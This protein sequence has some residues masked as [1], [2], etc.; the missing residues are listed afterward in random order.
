MEDLDEL[1]RH[2]AETTRLSPSEA[3]RVIA[4][5]VEFFTEPVEEFV[6]R[7]HAQLQNRSLT[8]PAIFEQISRE[9]S[10]RRFPSPGLSTR[11]IRRVIYG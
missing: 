7:R 8:N 3:S 10:A 11:Q 9:L 5:V 2:I 1:V 6:V 4:D